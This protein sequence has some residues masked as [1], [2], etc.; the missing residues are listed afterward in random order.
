MPWYLGDLHSF[1]SEEEEEQENN[2]ITTEAQSPF[3]QQTNP[4]SCKPS[5]ISRL[6]KKTV[7]EKALA[8]RP[9]A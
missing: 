1:F 9:P 5:W 8:R 3:L 7:E 4:K 6:Q 2:L